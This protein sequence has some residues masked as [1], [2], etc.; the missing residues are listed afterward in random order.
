[1]ADDLILDTNILVRHFAQD[2]VEHS[3]AA[4]NLLHRIES[5]GVRA[6]VTP[7]GIA[8]A[9]WVLSGPLYRFDRQSVRHQLAALLAIPNL[10]VLEMDVVLEALDLFADLNID[11]ID[12]YHAAVARKRGTDVYSFDHDF[13]RVPGIRRIEPER[14]AP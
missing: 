2:H 6:V 8:G 11:F 3:P 10:I 9:V 7:L 5:H 1:V 4:T 14:D 13:D 12:G